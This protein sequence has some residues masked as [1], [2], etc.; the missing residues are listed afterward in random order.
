MNAKI[1]IG[2]ASVAIAGGLFFL[3]VAANYGFAYFMEPENAYR[4]EHLQGVAL[5]MM[6]AI[7]FWLAASATLWPVKAALPRVAFITIN[8]VTVGLC[9]LFVVANVYPLI[10]V[11]LGA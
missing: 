2:L 7:P 6:M 10:M 4:H 5:A 8:V 11:V 1:W 3:G 9:A